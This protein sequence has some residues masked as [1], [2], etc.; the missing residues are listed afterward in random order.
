MEV[1][2]LAI[3]HYIVGSSVEHN[4]RRIRWV[5]V[6][7][8]IQSLEGLFVAFEREAHHGLF[9]SMV[10]GVLVATAHIVKINRT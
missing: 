1:Y 9:R 8:C 10:P 4:N 7:R 6:C 3:R 5:N 2:S